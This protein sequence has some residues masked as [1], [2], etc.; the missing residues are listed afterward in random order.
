MAGDEARV[1]LTYKAQQTGSSG[2]YRDG[3]RC[4]SGTVVQRQRMDIGERYEL[5][6]VIDFFVMRMASVGCDCKMLEQRYS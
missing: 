6:G 3:A 5:L 4:G 1:S 2:G